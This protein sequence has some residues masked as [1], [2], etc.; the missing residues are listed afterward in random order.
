MNI[1]IE[2]IDKTENSHKH[3]RK[4]EDNLQSYTTRVY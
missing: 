1:D 4:M 3:Y 2:N